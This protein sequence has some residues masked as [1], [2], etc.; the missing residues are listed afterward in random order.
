M[1]K[2]KG[3]I[4]KMFGDPQSGPTDFAELSVM[5]PRLFVLRPDSGSGLRFLNQ[6][7]QFESDLPIDP[8]T[9]GAGLRERILEES[10]R[11]SESQQAEFDDLIR[12]VSSAAEDFLKKLSFFVEVQSARL[13]EIE[14]VR[15]NLEGAQNASTLEETRSRISKGMSGLQK[16]AESELKRKTELCRDRDAYATRLEDKLETAERESRTDSLTGVANRT[17][18]M[19]KLDGVLDYVRTNGTEYSIALL[20]LNGFKRINDTLGHAAG[21]YALVTFAQR[22]EAAVGKSNFVGRLSGDE[23]VVVVS[24]SPGSLTS[25]LNRLA[26]QFASMP[27]NYKGLKLNVSFCF[28]ICRVPKS[29]TSTSLLEEADRILYRH[30]NDYYESLVA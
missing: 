11:F 18:C 13:A 12:D 3:V 4:R 16:I 2:W 9:E 15:A 6:L 26:E 19:K 27:A 28:G 23:F 10:T 7:G 30:K 17:G 25:L 20:D 22:L 1:Q 29:G 8:G 21:D 14:S 5:L 24:A